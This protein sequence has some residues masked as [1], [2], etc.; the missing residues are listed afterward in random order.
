MHQHTVMITKPTDFDP[1]N[2]FAPYIA[3]APGSDLIESLTESM[4]QTLLLFEAIPENQ[5]SFSYGDGKWTIKQ[6]F[7][8]IADCERIL[9]YRALR[10]ARHDKTDLSG[11]DE[12]SYAEY[13]NTAKLSLE[14]IKNDYLAVRLATIELYKSLNLE[15]I[16]FSGTG[17][18]K[19]SSARIMGW[20]ISGHDRHHCNVITDRYLTQ[21]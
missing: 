5:G 17:N 1:G 16:D 7:K 14:S 19:E 18:G 21:L 15:S 12:D 2:Y 3:N 9:S 11:F 8:H 10:F 20:V 4:H 13:D 6:V